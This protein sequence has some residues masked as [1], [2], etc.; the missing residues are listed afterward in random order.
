M[1]HGIRNSFLY[2]S[3]RIINHSLCT[4]G[5]QSTYGTGFWAKNS[6]GEICLITNKHVLKHNEDSSKFCNYFDVFVCYF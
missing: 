2:A 5:E 4:T 1:N 6:K 3:S